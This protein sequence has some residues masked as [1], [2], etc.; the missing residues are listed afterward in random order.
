MFRFIGHALSDGV[1]KYCEACRLFLVWKISIYGL[2]EV[3]ASFLFGP[4]TAS[5]SPNL[6]KRSTVRP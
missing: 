2:T 1:R 5:P 3:G 6:F 4:I